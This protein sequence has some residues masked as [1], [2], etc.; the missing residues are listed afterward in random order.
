MIPPHYSGLFRTFGYLLLAVYI[1]RLFF[2]IQM[3][4][5]LSD[6][7]NFAA[8]SVVHNHVLHVFNVLHPPVAVLSGDPSGSIR[9]LAF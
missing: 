8:T 1:H 9:N 6:L 3:L 5:L 2:A 7:L 4:F